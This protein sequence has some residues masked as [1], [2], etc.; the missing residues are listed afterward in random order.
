MFALLDFFKN[1]KNKTYTE[2]CLLL[3]MLRTQ[4]QEEINVTKDY[5]CIF[6]KNIKAGGNLEG[7]MVKQYL[8]EN[9]P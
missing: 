2:S 9:R 5:F 3:E 1:T 7:Q 6:T 4:M 8:T